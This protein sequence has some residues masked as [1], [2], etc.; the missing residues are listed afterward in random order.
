[1]PVGEPVKSHPGQLEDSCALL[2]PVPVL[3]SGD[4]YRRR[5]ALPAPAVRYSSTEPRHRKGIDVLC[6]DSGFSWLLLIF[7]RCNWLFYGYGALL[8][9]GNPC[10][11]EFLLSS[12]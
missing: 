4:R 1:M 2:G 9:L 10:K 6:P 7:Q 12:G 3:P 11:A 5:R 8:D